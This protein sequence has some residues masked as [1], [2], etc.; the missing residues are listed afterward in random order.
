MGKIIALILAFCQNAVKGKAD[1]VSGGT[2]NNV[3]VGNASGNPADSG[4]AIST[5]TGKADKVS[6]GTT[7][8]VLVVDANG[9][10]SDSGHSIDDVITSGIFTGELVDGEL[11]ITLTND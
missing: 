1:K 9:N 5:L 2:A 7:N 4:V 3:L 6:G 8:N 10:P 11:R